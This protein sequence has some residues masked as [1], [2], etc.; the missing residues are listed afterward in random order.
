[1]SQK[2]FEAK[3][4]KGG[5]SYAEVFNADITEDPDVEEYDIEMESLYCALTE[6]R[7]YDVE[8]EE[9]KEHEDDDYPPY[10]VYFPN[11]TIL[12]AARSYMMNFWDLSQWELT[13]SMMS[14]YDKEWKKR[15]EFIHEDGGYNP[16]YKDILSN[17]VHILPFGS[18][19]KFYY[20]SSIKDIPVNTVLKD[21]KQLDVE[22]L[23]CDY[24][25]R[26]FAL[27]MNHLFGAM[28]L[29]T[30][31]PVSVLSA[32]YYEIIGDGSVPSYTNQQLS[33]YMKEQAILQISNKK[34]HTTTMDE[35][36]SKL[37]ERYKGSDKIY[38]KNADKGGSRGGVI[39]EKKKKR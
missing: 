9:E 4:W 32:S 16:Q 3:W 22:V 33:D 1:M 8:F 34:G 25:S 13:D 6:E 18:Q 39:F 31:P 11:S 12:V 35:V 30:Y 36:V 5:P 14:K 24:I 7:V 29:V 26:P 17:D 38:V 37:N 2:R 15:K 28:N 19:N 23:I 10:H 21:I 27:K 20:S